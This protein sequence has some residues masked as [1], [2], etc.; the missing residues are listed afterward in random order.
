MVEECKPFLSKKSRRSFICPAGG[1]GAA[2]AAGVQVG[3]PAG[4][5][6]LCGDRRI[7]WAAG[8]PRLGPLP[9]HRHR[10][11]ARVPTG[12]EPGQR[13]RIRLIKAFVSVE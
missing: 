13:L 1:S 10:Q 7:G 9:L 2:S 11:G 6:E 12:H 3:G 5:G 4:D 8:D